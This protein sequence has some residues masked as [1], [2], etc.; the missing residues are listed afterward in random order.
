MEKEHYGAIDGLRTIGCMAFL[1]EFCISF[2][3]GV[4]FRNVLRILR[5]SYQK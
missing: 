4:R 1:Y 3:D 5:E 2:Y